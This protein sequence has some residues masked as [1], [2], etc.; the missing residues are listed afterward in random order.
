MRYSLGFWKGGH[1]ADAFAG[2]L[3]R[4]RQFGHAG[5]GSVF[6][7]GDPEENVG[8]AY[9]TNGIRDETEHRLR[10]NELADAVRTVY[11]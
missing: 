11:E 6:G 4:E 8:F 1:A 3:S 5:L 7:W 10:V 2:T 9:V